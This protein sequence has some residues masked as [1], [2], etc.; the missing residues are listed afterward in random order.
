MLS[1][2]F[3]GAF[4][5]HQ[6]SSDFGPEGLKPIIAQCLVA[7]SILMGLHAMYLM[8]MLYHLIF[9][10]PVEEQM[11]LAGLAFPIICLG[12]LAHAI[13]DYLKGLKH[14]EFSQIISVLL[15]TPFFFFVAYAILAIRSWI[16]LCIEWW[17]KRHKS[18]EEDPARP[19]Q[20]VRES[21]M[22][23]TDTIMVFGLIVMLLVGL[24]TKE[25]KNVPT[26]DAPAQIEA[27]GASLENAL[28]K[29]GAAIF[30]R[31]NPKDYIVLSALV[32]YA[33]AV[34]SARR[35]SEENRETLLLAFRPEF[36]AS[37]G[38]R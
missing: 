6:F 22:R 1:M 19:T 31:A 26:T 23:V 15:S 21:F 5:I 18:S 7:A 11:W 32:F 10:H 20:H 34:L 12:Y 38:T 4:D 28:I 13:R 30:K 25:E 2:L 24:N 8:L 3:S 16:K 14:D 29:I 17:H 9:R 35:K 36:A 33:A 27:V 37:A